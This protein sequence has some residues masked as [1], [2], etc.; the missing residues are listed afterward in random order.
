[1]PADEAPAVVAS[2]IDVQQHHVGGR[3][4]QY[5]QR[6]LSG[7]AIGHHLEIWFGAEQATEALSEE[8]VVVNQQQSDACHVPTI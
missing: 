8:D 6:R 4:V 1:M 3:P 5:L 2:E 7:P